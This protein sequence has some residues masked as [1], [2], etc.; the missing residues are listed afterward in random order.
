MPGGAG[1]AATQQPVLDTGVVIEAALSAGVLESAVWVAGSLLS[2]RQVPLP[3]EVTGVWGALTL[4]AVVAGERMAAAGRRL[5]GALLADADQHLLARMLNRLPPG[6]T[7]QVVLC[8]DAAALSL[9]VELIRLATGDGP[10]TAPLGLLPTVSVVR[11]PTGPGREPG[12]PPGP[13]PPRR[14]PR[15]PGR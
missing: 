4:P 13:P 15:W 3:T 14:A 8:A 12:T 10:E 9:P 7:A 2:H 11:R 6:G 1:P 5:A